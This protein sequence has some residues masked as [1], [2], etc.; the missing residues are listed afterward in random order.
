MTNSPKPAPDS[1]EVE[2]TPEQV[3]L[4]KPF[5]DFAKSEWGEKRAGSF[6]AQING[7]Y[8]HPTEGKIVGAIAKTIFFYNPYVKVLQ[9]VSQINAD[10]HTQLLVTQQLQSTNQSQGETQ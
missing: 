10:H 4:L 2:F 5:L 3:E 1:I 8:D 9:A 7:F 6:I